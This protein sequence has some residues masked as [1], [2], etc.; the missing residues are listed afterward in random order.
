MTSIRVLLVDARSMRAATLRAA[1]G[2]AGFEVVGVVPD[3]DDLYRAVEEFKPDAVI[4]DAD[5]PSRDT[6][7]HLASLERQYP[8]PLLMLSARDDRKTLIAAADAGVSA[9]VVEGFSPALVRSLVDVAIRQFRSVAALKDELTEV[10]ESMEGRKVID[11][12]KCLLMEQGGLSEKDAYAMLRKSA[13]DKGMP[14]VEVARAVL[15]HSAG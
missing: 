6:L 10:R 4:V 5:S 12:A 9:Y 3:T 8:K 13:M 2:E 11:R 14:L 1:L 15:Q 7:E